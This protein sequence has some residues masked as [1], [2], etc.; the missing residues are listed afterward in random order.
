MSERAGC[1]LF[2]QTRQVDVLHAASALAGRDE[3]VLGDLA[4]QTNAANEIIIQLLAGSGVRIDLEIV[5]VHYVFVGLVDHT[6]VFLNIAVG[7]HLLLQRVSHGLV[8]VFE[9]QLADQ[10]FKTSQLDAIALFQP[11]SV[12]G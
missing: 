1:L 5:Y 9:T 12:L 2:L 3:G 7:V 10:E 4:L 6:L 11:D 8:G